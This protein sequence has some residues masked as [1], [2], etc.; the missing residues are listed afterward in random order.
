MLASKLLSEII[1]NS[2]LPEMSQNIFRYAFDNNSKP[3]QSI[4]SNIQKQ[5]DILRASE[6]SCSDLNYS[7][8]IH[9]AYLQVLVNII[10]AIN[11][12]QDKSF[13]EDSQE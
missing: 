9:S 10:L 5:A 3:E 6:N 12:T 11:G 4:L 2:T 8:S 1:G 7:E 13:D